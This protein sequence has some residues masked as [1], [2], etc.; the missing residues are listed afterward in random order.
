M[1]AIHERSVIIVDENG[2]LSVNGNFNTLLVD[3]DSATLLAD[4]SLMLFC[5]FAVFI[6]KN[7]HN[8]HALWKSTGTL[9]AMPCQ[10]S[11]KFKPKRTK[12]REKTQ[13]ERQSRMMYGNYVATKYFNWKFRVKPFDSVHTH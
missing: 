1:S 2:H 3:R 11:T 9:N 12:E 8:L 5:L 10:K 4:N 13:N 7:Q 6:D